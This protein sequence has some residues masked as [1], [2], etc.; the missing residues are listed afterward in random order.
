MNYI[1]NRGK[2]PKKQKAISQVSHFDRSGEN[3]NKDLQDIVDNLISQ[4]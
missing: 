3:N 4:H 1:E 2:S